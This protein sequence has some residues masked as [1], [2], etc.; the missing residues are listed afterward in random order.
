[1]RE[2]PSRAERYDPAADRSRTG[3]TPPS[4]G[5]RPHAIRRSLAA[6]AA[7]LLASGAAA[8]C[9]G[10]G[11]RVEVTLLSTTDVHGYLLPWSYSEAR[12]TDSS[13]VQLATMVDSIRDADPHVVLLDSGDFLQG[14]ELTD[15]VAAT[16]IDSVHPIVAAM[17]ELDYD[18]AALGNHEYN[19]GLPFLHEALSGGE[20]PFL[21]AN[22]Y[23]AD[24][25]SLVFPPYTVVERGPVKIGVL[26]LTTPGVA[27]WDRDHVEGRYRFED[28]IASAERWLAEMRA[29][30]DP[31]VV[32]V[33]A[34]SGIDPGVTY[35]EDATGVQQEAA[36]GQLVRE[37]DGIDV[38][39]AGHTAGPVAPREIGGALV[40]HAGH[41]G[42]ALA[43]VRVALERAGD[44]S[45]RVADR[46]GSLLDAAGHPPHAEVER[47]VRPAHD[48]TQAWLDE[49]LAYTPDRWSAEEARVRD[50]PAADLIT[51]AMLDATGAEVA[52][53]AV[54]DPSVAFGPGVITR[55]DVLALYRY[56]NRL[57]SVRVSG[58][59]VRAYLERSARY[60]NRYPAEA[61]ELINDSVIAFNYDVLEG[62]DYRIDLTRP[63]GER[64]RGLRHEGEPVT[65]TDT[66]TLAVNSYRQSGGGG[67][68]TLVDAPV[69]YSGDE[70]VSEVIVDFIGRHDTLRTAEVHREN[71]TL[72]PEEAVRRLVESGVAASR[73]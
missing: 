3:S 49:E 14:S 47:V 59:D 5:E 73:Y 67:F 63:T 23:H 29:E 57:K 39:F 60:Y 51:S 68:S 22:T 40:T 15:Y 19:H 69:A 64:I 72:S 8:A 55:R 20:F 61:E 9:Q 27:V 34:H 16:G 7:V 62:V 65:G 13:L 52:S 37:I 25:D 21:S 17:N 4:A 56:P 10:D 32:V 66:L 44:G 58:A 71:W 42:E 70:V 12:A 30:H 35:G 36:V 46:S 31:D 45:W 2:P 33:A 28:M 18:A 24:T 54:F 50:T 53:T 6:I 43:A 38:V 48:A 1:M 41:Q 11:E 26:G